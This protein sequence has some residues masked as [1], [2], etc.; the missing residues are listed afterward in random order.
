MLSAADLIRLCSCSVKISICRSIVA[1]VEV[2]SPL[3]SRKHCFLSAEE[4]FSITVA[5]HPAVLRSVEHMI[6][7]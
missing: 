5:L 3:L 1:G 4:V 7:D 2:V 6:Q